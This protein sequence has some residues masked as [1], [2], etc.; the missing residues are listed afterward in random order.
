MIEEP[1]F[2]VGIEEEYLI[3]DPE[4]RDLIRQAPPGLISRCQELLDE[5][6]VLDR[7]EDVLTAADA[8]EQQLGNTAERIELVGVGKGR[9]VVMHAAALG[10]RFAVVMAHS[11]FVSWIDGVLLVLEAGKTRRE[12]ARHVVES[13]RQVGANLVGVVL[14]AVPHPQGSYYYYSYDE[15]YE[16]GSGNRKPRRQKGRLT[17]VRRLF[18]RR[19]KAADGD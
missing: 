1:R 7:V 2:T 14:N 10:P 6:Q 16:D 3:V 17:A 5:R 15:Y 19:R 11:G 4:S 18:G 13:L 9:P 12:S 8:L